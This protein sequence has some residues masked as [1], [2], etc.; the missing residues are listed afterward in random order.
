MQ[1]NGGQKVVRELLNRYDRYSRVLNFPSDWGERAF[2]GWLVFDLFHNFLKWNSGHIVFGERY[3]V[4][5]VDDDL[6]PRIYI[7]TKK[8][9]I[10]LVKE[11]INK[12]EKRCP[13]YPTLRYAVMSDGYEWLLIDIP[14]ES[15]IHTKLMA[16]DFDSVIMKL[17]SQR[18][19]R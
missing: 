7:E 14:A 8:P 13:H 1:K 4:L 10:G 17:H 5:L 11:E 2:R 15:R 3:D 16:K 12:F 18:F 9:K 6:R 19:L